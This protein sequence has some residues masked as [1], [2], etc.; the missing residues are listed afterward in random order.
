MKKRIQQ[1]KSKASRRRLRDLEPL[2]PAERQLLLDYT[3]GAVS[4][5]AESCPQQMTEANLLRADFIYLLASGLDETVLSNPKGINVRGAWVEGTVNLRN[6]K[7]IGSFGF[8]NS[9]INGNLIF[10][11]ADVH[12]VLLPGT[13][14][15]DISANQLNCRG[16]IHLRDGFRSTGKVSLGGAKIGGN[17]DCSNGRFDNPG[18]EAIDC[19]GAEV[20]GH[21]W[22]KGDFIARG[23]V[24][25]SRIHV[26]GV[27]SCEGRFEN[28]GGYAI[29]CYGADIQG[30]L[31]MG[32][33]FHARGEV[34]LAFSSIGGNFGCSGGFFEN[35]EGLALDCEGLNVRGSVFFSRGFHIVGQLRLVAARIDRD[36]TFAGGVFGDVA[37]NENASIDLSRSEIRGSIIFGEIEG[38]LTSFGLRAASTNALI[39][40][41][42]S[43]RRADAIVLDGFK[44][45]RFLDWEFTFKKIQHLTPTDA[46][47]RI[48][49]LD[50][51]RPD[52]LKE[53]F[54]SQPWEHL[55]GVLRATGQ[56]EQARIVAI[57]KQ[58]RLRAADQIS[59]L[60]GAFHDLYGALYGYGYRPTR[61]LIC[62][63]AVWIMCGLAFMAAAEQG[64]M[65][66]TDKRLMREASTLC[67][68]QKRTWTNCPQVALE[69]SAFNP[70]IYSLDLIVPLVSL[71]HAKDW[72]PRAIEDCKTTKFY[73]CWE[74]RIGGKASESDKV[75]YSVLGIL[76]GMLAWLESIFGWLVGLM[77]VAVASGLV[78]KD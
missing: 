36:L 10:N 7:V 77:F 69:Y 71:Q 58:D 76:I 54:K 40:D 17:L 33:S 78:K 11:D 50:R 23:K 31:L 32:G 30:F 66:P 43:W 2:F 12:N 15:R 34:W 51:Q 3:A 62:V 18:K 14:V 45:E 60:A 25:L 20:R 55:V 24:T 41:R 21:V 19:E 59:G 74:P 46:P 47:T 61:L 72:Q 65:V 38:R 27:L 48:E 67:P 68:A 29:S 44:Y 53:N 52:H 28:P 5:V 70:F 8:F 16:S 1:E 75:G 39:D 13:T 49:W 73:I 26:R 22:L 6:C 35:P 37:K 9:V 4:D 63:I 64:V 56:F 42:E 57:A